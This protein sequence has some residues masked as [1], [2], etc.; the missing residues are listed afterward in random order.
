M[1]YE[2]VLTPGEIHFSTCRLIAL[3]GGDERGNRDVRDDGT[4]T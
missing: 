1:A 2:I 4:S 3:N